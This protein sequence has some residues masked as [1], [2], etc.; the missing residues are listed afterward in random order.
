MS[1]RETDAVTAILSNPENDELSAEEVAERVISALDAARAAT[2][3]LIVV[4]RFSFDGVETFEAALGPLSTR[5]PAAAR[6]LGERFAWDYK[7]RLGSGMYQFL[8]LLR[9]PA[10]AWDHARARARKDE[11]PVGRE[12][13]H[14][15]LEQDVQ[16]A[17]SE[18]MAWRH[19]PDDLDFWAPACVCSLKNQA[20]SGTGDQFQTEEP[21]PLARCFRH[22]EGHP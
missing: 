7:T 10:A 1:K 22:P 12:D 9:T 8:P 18:A 4:G 15:P 13:P 19:D 2:H 5:A 21:T 6:A 3:N 14:M 20:R 11:K 16:H 17:V